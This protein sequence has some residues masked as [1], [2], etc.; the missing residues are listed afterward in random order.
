MVNGVVGACVLGEFNSQLVL[1]GVTREANA[2]LYR[3]VL[4]IERGRVGLHRP[5]SAPRHTVSVMYVGVGTWTT[6]N[7]CRHSF[8]AVSC[9][10][11]T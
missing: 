3:H 11:P 8:T 2:W 9:C 4:H 10:I 7:Y 6:H 1:K 5:D